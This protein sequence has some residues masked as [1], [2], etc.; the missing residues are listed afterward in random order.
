[1]PDHPYARRRPGRS[2][3]LI[4]EHR[5][6][7][8]RHL[9]RNLLPSEI[10]D[11]IDGLHLHNSPANLRLF[12]SN[13]DHLRATI[14]G[15]TPK[16]SAAGWARMTLS[17]DR[18]ADVPPVDTYRQRKARG[19]VRLLQILLLA[20]R[21]GTAS[22]FLLGTHRHLAKAGIVDLSHP[23]I[24]RELRHR[25]PEWASAHAL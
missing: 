18:R 14:T 4:L 25:F 19:D 2:Y 16:W 21:L 15:Q 6:V 17:P 7:M 1:P 8:E 20:Y 9:G 12:A 13:A 10:V 3:G 24:E 22:P 5:A 11:H 23:T